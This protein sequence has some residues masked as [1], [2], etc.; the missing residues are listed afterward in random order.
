MDVKMKSLRTHQIN[1]EL[2]C[3]PPATFIVSNIAHLNGSNIYHTEVVR[4]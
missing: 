4:G 1:Q 3:L 2:I